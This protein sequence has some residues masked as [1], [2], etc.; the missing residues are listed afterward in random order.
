MFINIVR[1]RRLP[2]PSVRLGARPCHPLRLAQRQGTLS[3]EF[4]RNFLPV[5]KDFTIPAANFLPVGNGSA[6]LA[7]SRRQNVRIARD[8]RHNRGKGVD[9]AK[10][11]VSKCPVTRPECLVAGIL[12]DEH[13]AIKLDG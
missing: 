8:A 5:G 7:D 9:R 2:W 13:L 12:V 1:G 3:T 4:L 11:F 6:K 10:W